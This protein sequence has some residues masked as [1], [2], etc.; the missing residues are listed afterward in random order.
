MPRSGSR[1]L[2]TIISSYLEQTEGYGNHLNEYF[3]QHYVEKFKQIA[4]DNNEIEL[5][6]GVKA[7]H[8]ERDER[9]RLLKKYPNHFFKLFP[10]DL[11]SYYKRYDCRED[12]FL[13]WIRNNYQIITLERNDKRRQ[14]LSNCLVFNG[15]VNA[16]YNKVHDFSHTETI[17]VS[18]LF[19]F[20][21]L[22]GHISLINLKKMLNCPI[23]LIYEDW[24]NGGY[25]Y[26][27]KNGLWSNNLM[28]PR[29]PVK[30]LYDPADYIENID[31]V[32]SWFRM[33]PDVYGK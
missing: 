7:W 16:H 4:V 31:E 14:F 26:L 15:L 3:Q 24:V 10:R 1:C 12:T 22:H 29:I 11:T 9:W 25:A 13:Y 30:N 27:E 28:K 2:T 32:N 17:N 18:E 21:D 33:Y 20:N 19:F 6:K 8:E 5:I 23:N